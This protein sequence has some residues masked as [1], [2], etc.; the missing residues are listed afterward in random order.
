MKSKLYNLMLTCNRCI[1]V[2]IMFKINVR[3][4]TVQR[5][6]EMWSPLMYQLLNFR[7]FIRHAKLSAEDLS[8]HLCDTIRR[9][10]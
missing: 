8:G 9:C 7:N 1:Q 4:V 10:I 3:N 2:E 5:D 6:T